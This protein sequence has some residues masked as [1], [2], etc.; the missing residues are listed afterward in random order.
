[1]FAENISASGLQPMPGGQLVE[2]LQISARQTVGAPAEAGPHWFARWCW[3][4]LAD[5]DLLVHGM[6]G[7]HCLNRSSSLLGGGFYG[8]L[9]VIFK[10]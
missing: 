7:I 4:G 1:M 10:I 9:S 3:V 2:N 8:M 6:T 5:R